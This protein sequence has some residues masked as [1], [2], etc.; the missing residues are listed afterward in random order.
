[1]KA[2]LLVIL[3]IQDNRG[4]TVTTVSEPLP[5]MIVC[6]TALTII[7]QELKVNAEKAKMG[8]Y[9]IVTPLVARCVPTNRDL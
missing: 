9:P 3:L 8:V 1:M 6:N 5:T 7:E 4:V 2:L